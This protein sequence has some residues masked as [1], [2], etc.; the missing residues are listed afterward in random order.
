MKK[1]DMSNQTTRCGICIDDIKVDRLLD[2]N[3]NEALIRCIESSGMSMAQFCKVTGIAQTSIVRYRQKTAVPTLETIVTVCIALR[4]NVFQAL[5]LISIA[6]Y[7]IFYSEE[8]KVYLL[9]IM[10][11]WCFGISIDEAND[12]LISLNMKPLKKQISND[13]GGQDNGQSIGYHGNRH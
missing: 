9:L 5:Y 7:N 12:I 6:G 1:N 13:D 11:S 8:K 4:T 3:I 2:D 10:L